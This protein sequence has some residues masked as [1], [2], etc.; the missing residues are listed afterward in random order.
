M[1][2]AATVSR[3]CLS[4]RDV[5]WPQK[6]ALHTF[7]I[8]LLAFADTENLNCRHR[9]VCHTK[10]SKGTTK[11]KPKSYKVSFLLEKYWVQEVLRSV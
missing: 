5:R 11:I 6:S 2:S 10:F 7:Y 9:R 4:R 1:I 3:K 8:K